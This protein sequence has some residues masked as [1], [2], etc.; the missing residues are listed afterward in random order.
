MPSPELPSTSHIE[1]VLTSATG[2]P[3]RVES[4]DHLHPWSVLRC[5]VA[6]PLSDGASSLIV[7]WVRAEAGEGRS[8]PA[9]LAVERAALEHVGG[10]A[11]NLVPHVLAGG[12]DSGLLVLEDLAPREPLRAI[13]LRDGPIVAHREL[14][15]FARALGTLHA[16]TAGSADAFYRLRGVDATAGLAADLAASVAQFQLGVERIGAAGVPMSTAARHELSGVVDG[17]LDPGPLLALSNG[18]PETNNYLT[19]GSDGRLLDFESAGFASVFVDVASLYIPG[20]MW[21]SVGDPGSD[22][23]ADAYRS[24]LAPSIPEITDDRR[25]GAGVAGAGFVEALRRLVSLPKLDVRE[26]GES[27]RVHRVAT[28]EAAADTAARFGVLP[29]LTSWAREVG[30]LLRRRWPDTDVDLTAVPPFT[31]R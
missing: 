25:F 24:A 4:V 21:L 8:E 19:D 13:L 28:T 20:P 6:E 18:D 3:V 14:I 9:R 23:R 27:G 29:H 5:R 10:L 7:K 11:P 2:T 1:A 17:V 31:S 12:T 15:D 26:P 22:G 30:E 16:T